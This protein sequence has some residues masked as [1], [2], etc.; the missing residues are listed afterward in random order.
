[1][2]NEEVVKLSEYEKVK[3]ELAK[4]KN[5]SCIWCRH[6]DHNCNEFSCEKLSGHTI[7]SNDKLP[8]RICDDRNDSYYNYFKIIDPFKFCCMLFED[9]MLKCCNNCNK[10]NYEEGFTF[11]KQIV[12]KGL[13]HKNN[14]IE[15]IEAVIENP[16]KFHCSHHAYKDE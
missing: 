9:D 1:M 13:D 12:K 15:T 10:S 4:L 3:T 7:F 8:V 6:I 5:R 2:Y 11:C 16:D 14:F